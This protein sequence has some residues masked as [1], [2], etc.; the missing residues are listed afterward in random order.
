MKR[1]QTIAIAL[2]LSAAIST[3]AVA[4]LQTHRPA[5]PTLGQVPAFTLTGADGKPFGTRD[6]DGT[7]WVADFVFTSCPEVCPRMTSEMARLQTWL[8]NRGLDGRVRLVS[9]SVDPT[10]D[11]PDKLRA[12]AAQFHARPTWAFLTGPQKTVEDAVVRGFKI[13]M[14]RDQDDSQDGFAIVH[15]TRFVLVDGKQRIR[16]YYDSGDPAAL[17]KLRSDA[18][19]LADGAR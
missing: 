6:L 10:H 16:G 19:A 8:V 15:G 14:G 17:A 1:N 12:Y 3:A 9:I 2:A 4:M 18:Q 13:A 11:T 7:V 5:L